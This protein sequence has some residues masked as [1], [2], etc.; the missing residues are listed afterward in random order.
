M[1]FVGLV[2]WQNYVRATS[3]TYAPLQGALHLCKTV[4]ACAK[5]VYKYTSVSRYGRERERGRGAGQGREVSRE[6]GSRSA[7]AGQEWHEWGRGSTV[8]FRYVRYIVPFRSAPWH[9]AF[10][11][12]RQVAEP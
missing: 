7:G 3:R 11:A 8:P 5:V 6:R 2:R 1:G 4:Q 10:S 9:I 12:Q